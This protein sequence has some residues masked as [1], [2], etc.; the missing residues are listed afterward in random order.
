MNK[1]TATV[2]MVSTFRE[3]EAALLDESVLS[4]KI[5]ADITFENNISYIPLRSVVVDGDGHKINTGK[6]A[7]YADSNKINT[8]SLTIKN[9]TIVGDADVGRVFEHPSTGWD[10]FVSDVTY[11]GMRFA[12]L[13]C[14]TITFSGA[15][16]ITTNAENAWVEN[17]IFEASSKYTGVAARVGEF[18]A[19]YFNGNAVNGKATVKESAEVSLTIGDGKYA[20]YPAFWDRVELIE[21]D[22]SAQLAINSYGYAVHFNRADME[23]N[24]RITVAENAILSLTSDGGNNHEAVKFDQVGTIEVADGG[25]LFIAGNPK[26]NTKGIIS[27]ASGSE[28]IMGT[29]RDFKFFNRTKSAPIFDTANTRITLHVV[30]KIS[31]WARI[32]GEYDN[33]PLTSWS[34]ARMAT[35]VDGSASFNTTSTVDALQDNFQMDDYG[36]FSAHDEASL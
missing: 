22:K 8:Y 12:H 29:V 20:T 25:S 15:N 36:C 27:M 11:T 5:T 30:D 24:A 23:K 26:S 10:L 32:G 21:V 9:A 3:L 2:I 33:A 6:Y 4:I 1:S 34:D 35:I 7:I 14:G 18:S 13:S 16:N 31:V 19:F 17:V 28:I